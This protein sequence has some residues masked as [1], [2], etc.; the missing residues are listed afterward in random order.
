[1]NKHI[2]AGNMALYAADALTTDRPW[3]L[4]EF[5]GGRGAWQSLTG[6]PTW[7][8]K[9]PY[10]RKLKQHTIVLNTEQL[11]EVVRACRHVGWENEDFASAVQLL[12]KAL[13]VE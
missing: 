5:D 10:R 11:K 13:R 12:V 8:T 7:L 1:M 6:N 9:H 3:E 2:H 4:W